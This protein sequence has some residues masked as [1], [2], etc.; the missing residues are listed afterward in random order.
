MVRSWIILPSLTF[1]RKHSIPLCTKQLENVTINN[2]VY[3]IDYQIFHFFSVNLDRKVAIIVSLAIFPDVILSFTLFSFQ[4]LDLSLW[5][6]K[7]D[8]IYARAVSSLCKRKFGVVTCPQKSNKNQAKCSQ[9]LE[10]RLSLY[11]LQLRG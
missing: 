3:T 9:A 1:L 11:P 6:W 4:T 2:F 10:P 8:V 5:I 7:E